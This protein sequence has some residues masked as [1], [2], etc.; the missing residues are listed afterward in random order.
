MI[1]GA[2]LDVATVI[3]CALNAIS[4]QQAIAMALPAALLTAGGLIALLLP[5][6]WCA[7]RRGFMHGCQAAA[8]SDPSPAVDVAQN[9]V[10]KGLRK[11]RLSA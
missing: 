5:D 4:A 11:V 8:R 2:I 3:V 9:K 1:T 7:W 10:N 6:P